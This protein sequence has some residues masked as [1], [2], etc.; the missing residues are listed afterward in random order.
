MGNKLP[1]LGSIDQTPNGP[2]LDRLDARGPKNVVVIAMANKLAR[3]SWAV[4]SS[5]EG[6]RP[7]P[8]M[9]E[10]TKGQPERRP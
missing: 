8:I 7:L 4:L 2:G 3:I 1:G 10:R 5:A 6:Y 9:S